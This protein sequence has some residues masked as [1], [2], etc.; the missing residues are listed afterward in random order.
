[1]RK[2]RPKRPTQHR[3]GVLRIPRGVRVTF[4]ARAFDADAPRRWSGDSPMTDPV[5]DEIANRQRTEDA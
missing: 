5:P 1:M 2:R 3:F 4:D